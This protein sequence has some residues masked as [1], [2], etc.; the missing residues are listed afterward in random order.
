MV[1]MQIRQRGIMRRNLPFRRVYLG[2]GRLLY[3]NGAGVRLE[4]K[5]VFNSFNDNAKASNMSMSYFSRV[6]T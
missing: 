3:R 6:L 5:Q 1:S 4:L 2:L